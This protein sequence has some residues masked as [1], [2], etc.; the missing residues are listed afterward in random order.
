MEIIMEEL[1]TNLTK[2]YIDKCNIK[3]LP[4]LQVLIVEDIYEEYLKSEIDEWK[5]SEIK[6]QKDIISGNNGLTIYPSSHRDY[7]IILI[8]KEE[9]EKS[10][11]NNLLM[12]CTLWHELTHV[13]DFQNFANT[14]IKMV[15]NF[16]IG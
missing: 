14:F 15:S 4:Q 12:I 5:I 11:E 13:I 9:V 3:Q 16:H 1:F 6:R 10:Q 7:F 8:T 2:L